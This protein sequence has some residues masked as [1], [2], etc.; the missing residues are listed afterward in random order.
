[1]TAVFLINRMPSPLLENKSPIER[2]LGKVPD[3]TLLKSFGCLCFVSTNNKDRHKFSPPTVPCVFLGYPS[4]F[5]GYRVLNLESHA[6]TISRNVIFKEKMF[7]FKTT[8]VLSHDVDMFPNTILPL[9]ALLHF[10]ET[11]PLLSAE[12]RTNIS[13]MHDIFIDIDFVPSL[14]CS[15]THSTLDASRTVTVLEDTV[16]DLTNFPRPKRTTRAPTYL[17]Q[18]H[19]SCVSSLPVSL[20][21]LPRL[22]SSDSHHNVFLV[23]SSSFSSPS[24]PSSS[25]TPYP[26]SSTVSYDHFNPVFQSYVH[27]YNL[28][29]EPKTFK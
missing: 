11:M 9:P 20:T 18:Y 12:E 22:L 7:P 8:E 10:V 19:C 24:F 13:L 16:T 2:L 14:T 6:I 25:K 15:H 17:S 5:K 1:M 4:G 27:S 28:E 21:R 3:Y 29:I 23:P 26:I